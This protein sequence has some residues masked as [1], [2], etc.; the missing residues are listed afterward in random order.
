[1]L[2]SHPPTQALL[3]IQRPEDERWL[4]SLRVSTL[5]FQAMRGRYEKLQEM[6]FISAT[7]VD[8]LK[9]NG[10]TPTHYRPILEPGETQ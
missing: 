10:F 1:M 3:L 9:S 4:C 7:L 8:T 5:L 2:I 6:R